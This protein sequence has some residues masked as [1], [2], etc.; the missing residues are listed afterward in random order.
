MDLARFRET[1]IARCG[2]APERPLVVG[3][4]GGP[5][6]L[7]LLDS[8]ARLSFNVT[9]AH[10]DHR[11]RPESPQDAAAARRAAL[12]IGVPFVSES[13]DVTAYARAAGLT[14][15]EAAR[16]LRYRFLFD[17]ARRLSAQAVAVGHSADDQ[18]ETLLHHLLRGTGLEGLTG[19]AY[20]S[21][22]P[23]WDPAIPVVRPLLDTWRAEI[24]DCCRDRG[25]QPLID[26][27]NTDTAFFR[28]RLRHEL[29]PYLER[30][31]PQARRGLWRTAQILS[32]DAE[33][34]RA[35]AGEALALCSPR[36]EEGAVGLRLPPFADLPLGLRRAVLR[37]AAA[38]L[39][40][41]TRDLD[42]AAVERA[43][44][45]IERPGPGQVDLTRGLRLFVE[46]DWIWIASSADVPAQWPQLQ[47]DPLSLPLP[48]QVTVAPGWLLT[49]AV[50]PAS[51]APRNFEPR[52]AAWEAWLD[53]AAL[54]GPLSLRRPVPG[55]RFQPLGMASGAQK[56][57]DFWVNVKLP[58]RA[59]SAW[60]LVVSGDAIVWVP[61]FRLAHP[62]R[63]RPETR[64]TVHLR[65]FRA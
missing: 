21:V 4:S 63:L 39:L 14:L 8:L 40:P 23:E 50:E 54:P 5:D 35:A 47:S 43:V 62:Y 25:L 16:G 42:F 24:E 32:A 36:F 53:S 55:D 2:L 18:V 38:H 1:L 30:Y 58:R 64:Q 61:G 60:P 59:R 11:L 7:C 56:L 26:P 19:M 45:W 3:F 31:N 9:A 33:V 20:R 44:A 34:L 22:K 15:E 41:G 12:N 29:I 17:Q 48:G 51:A 37:Q 65:L 28:N 10:F 49:A 13:G 46:G 6:S 57:S 52:A 27:S